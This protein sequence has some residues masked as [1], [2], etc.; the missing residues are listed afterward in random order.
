MMKA[1]GSV[2]TGI[3]RRDRLIQ[4]EVHDP[5]MAGAKP[6]E[7]NVCRDCGVVFNKGR[8]QWLP[9]PPARAAEVV[10]PACRR[11]RDGVPAGFLTLS[12]TFFHEHRD[13]IMNLVE[14]KVESQEKEHPMKRLMHAEDRGEVTE[15]TFTDAHLPRGVGE[16][17]QRA[18]DGDLDIHFPEGGGIVRVYW[19][20]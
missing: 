9:E 20:R 5:Y 14:N 10:C 18:Y 16:A 6:A 11:V 19:E 1:D 13:E 8:W 7:P 15:L 17:I 12:G 3:R 4:E 2:A